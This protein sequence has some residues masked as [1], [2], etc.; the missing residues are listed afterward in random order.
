MPRPGS[1]IEKSKDFKGS[2]KKIISSLSKWHTIIIISF[3]LAMASAIMYLIAPNKL[4]DLTNHIT[5]GIKP[6]I[7]EKVITE[8]INDDSI[9]ANDKQEFL[10]V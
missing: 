9:S 5:D 8:I 3:V 7:N 6:N 4:S 10:Q 1:K 2:I